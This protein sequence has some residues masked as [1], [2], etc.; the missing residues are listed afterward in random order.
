M[1]NTHVLVVDDEVLYR[2]AIERILARAGHQVHTAQ[3]A[4]DALGVVSRQ[5]VDVVVCDLRM[6]GTNGLE[7]VRL[8]REIAPDL[9]AIVITGFSSAENSVDALFAGAFWY[10]EKPFEQAHFDVFRR[11]VSRA[12]EHGRFRSEN[13]ER[14]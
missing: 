4:I 8:L 6:P 11:L 14:Q 9:P 1:P 5:S 3:N 12:I 10:L 7:F 2:Q 13:R